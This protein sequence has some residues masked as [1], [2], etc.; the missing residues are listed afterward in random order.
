[1]ADREQAAGQGGKLFQ[2]LVSICIPAY[3]SS[4]TIEG[5]VRSIL[6]QTYKNLELIIV[7]DNSKDDTVS[8]VKRFQEE[9]RRIRLYQNGQNLGMSGNWN[10]CLKLCQGEYI[11]LVCAD[12]Q[13]YP[14]AIEREARAMLEHPSVNLVESDTRLVDVNGKTTGAFKRYYRS[15]VVDGRKAAKTSLM[16]NNFFGAPVNNLIRRSVLS[17]TGLFDTTF[18]YILDFDMWV[19]IACIGDIYIIHEPL[20]SFMVRGDSNTGVM[21]GQ[22]RDVY[23]AEHRRLVEK[24]AAAGI[25][26]IS[27][28]EVALSVLL[29]RMRNV[30]IGIYLKIF[31]K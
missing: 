2:P 11:K 27:R 14:E 29:R 19:R 1:M 13:L 16:L 17:K 8:V 28:F 24:H 18:T 25:L 3:N 21:I 12:D 7:D 22:K 4:A 15:G 30:A 20:N 5:T 10:H 26:R 23:V 6:N 31:A 9:D